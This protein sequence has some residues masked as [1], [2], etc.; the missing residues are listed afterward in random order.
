[1]ATLVEHE[2]PGPRPEI[3]ARSDNAAPAHEHGSRCENRF[4]RHALSPPSVDGQEDRLKVGCH[5]RRAFAVVPA[6]RCLG[7]GAAKAWDPTSRGFLLL[8]NRR[9]GPRLN[10]TGPGPQDKDKRRQLTSTRVAQI[11]YSGRRSCP[12]R[13][14]RTAMADQAKSGGWLK[15]LFTT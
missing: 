13:S 2:L 9:L 6:L 10:C 14:R 8:K 11:S 12:I 4:I 5:G 3:V 7:A 1:V 15:G